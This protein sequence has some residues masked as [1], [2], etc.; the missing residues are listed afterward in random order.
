MRISAEELLVRRFDDLLLGLSAR[1]DYEVVKVGAILRQLLLDD[2]PLMH[3]ANR[4]HRLKLRFT[5]NDIFSKPL[6]IQPDVQFVAGGFDPSMVSLPAGTKSISLGQFLGLEILNSRTHKFTVRE[7]IKYAA[8]KAGGVHFGETLDAREAELLRTIEK[9]EG[10]GFPAIAIALRSVSRVTLTM[11]APLRQAIV[12]LPSSLPLAAHYK[13]N[14]E[15]SIHFAGKQFLETDNYN[16]ESAP[17]FSWNGVLRI[18]KQKGSGKKVIY[19]LGRWP[20]TR[21]SPQFTIYLNNRQQIGCAARLSSK[22]TLD[23]I[24][25]SSNAFPTFDHFVYLSCELCLEN[26]NA[27]L[28]VRINGSTINS[29]TIAYRG[30]L[31][32]MNRQV[33]GANLAGKQHSSFYIRELVL[34]HRCLDPKERKELAKYFWLEWHD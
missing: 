31:E 25:S 21:Y 7:L 33:I 6:P 10:I 24:A 18:I 3:K 4:H 5:V 16:L 23:V 26:G 17:G 19:E 15:G 11:L 30:T 27:V 2:I 34:A 28:S 29:F 20:R 22:E 14:K 12:K 13:V 9:V 8:N 1:D 32:K